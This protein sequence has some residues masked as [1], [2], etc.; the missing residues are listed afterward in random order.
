MALKQNRQSSNDEKLQSLEQELADV[1]QQLAATQNELSRASRPVEDDQ[2]Q[3]ELVKWR[4]QIE[5]LQRMVENLP[6]G[7]VYLDKDRMTMNRAAEEITGYERGELKTLD[8]WFTKLY[9]ERAVENRRIYESYR[10]AG[11]TQTTPAIMIIRKDGSQ[12]FVEFAGYRFDDQEVWLMY[13]ITKRHLYAEAL[14]SSEERVQA[15]MDNASEAIVVIGGDGVITDYNIAAENLFG[16]SASETIGKNVSLLM[17]SPYREKHDTFIRNYKRTGISKI[18]RQRRELPG[19]RKDGSIIPLEITVAEIDHRNLFCG[20]IRDLSEHKLLEKEIADICTL[21]QER[22]GQDI[23][24][25][26]GQ[27]LTGLSMM[28]TSLKHDLEKQHLPQARQL[29]EMIGYLNQ[30]SEEAHTLSHGLAPIS[31]MP[32]GLSDALHK[33]AENIRTTTGINC[34]FESDQ[35][36]ENMDVTFSMQLYRI[37]QE[38]VN[39]AVKYANPRLIKIRLESVDG[40]VLTVS[41]DGRGFDVDEM[42]PKRFGLRIM[43]YRAGIIGFKLEI[44]SSPGEG[45]VVQCRQEPVAG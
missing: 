1:K 23:H 2:E 21:E 3:K 12:R 22:I 13:D 15:I 18:M 7:A 20:M 41:D 10:D 29:G 36:V 40:Y 25:G 8:E 37:A 17:P 35:S 31:I 39:N 14:R 5:R 28:A 27:Q 32:Q 34:R 33:L 19:R 38:A 6:A 30:A 45:T 42:M 43:R 26:L 44:R 11:F 4:K 24:D 16:Y 9:R